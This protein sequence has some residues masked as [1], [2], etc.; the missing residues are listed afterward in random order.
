[1]HHHDVRWEKKK[2][3]CD[4]ESLSNKKTLNSS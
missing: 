2:K 1:M 4:V 3:K